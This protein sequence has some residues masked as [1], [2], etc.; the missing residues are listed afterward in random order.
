MMLK[1]ED[2]LKTEKEVEIF[3]YSTTYEEAS[4]CKECILKRQVDEDDLYTE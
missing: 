3:L 1:C 2:C 4:L